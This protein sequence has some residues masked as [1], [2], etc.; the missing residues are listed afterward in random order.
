[1]KGN[2]LVW[3]ATALLV[4][5]GLAC[6]GG[7]T[8]TPEVPPT[9]EEQPTPEKKPAAEQQATPQ[10]KA[11]GPP[12][13]TPEPA[14]EGAT[15]EITNDSGVDVWYI[16]LSPSKA[17]RWGENWLGDHVIRNGE[18]HTIEGIPE[19]RYDVQ[20]ADQNEEVVEMWSEVDV[21]GVIPWSIE[22]LASLEVINE[23]STTIT[24][25]YIS[26]PEDTSW[27]DP[28]LS[29]QAIGP[30]ESLTIGDIPRGAYDVKV[31]DADGDAIEVIYSVGLA[32]ELSWE[33]IGKTS[34]PGNAVLRFEDEFE[35]NRNNWG[36]DVEG[37]DVFYK[38]PAN[39]QYC[40]LIKSENF[41]AWEWYEPFR[42]D[43]FVAEVFCEVAGAEG[44]TC[45]L[46]FGPDGDN[47]YWFEV[48]AGDQAF[49]F[50][51][52]ENG[53]WQEELV[54][55]TTSFRIDPDGSNA[56]SLERVGGVVSLI[57]NAV[58]V[59]QADGS[60]FPTGRVGIGGST[61]DVGYADVCLDNLRVWRLE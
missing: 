30:G 17:E 13:D 39:G 35:N 54:E 53:S 43:E 1:M 12:T 19:G 59:A 60:R 49:A 22:G 45:G 10:Q 44:A 3:L 51:L 15:L 52:L 8:P 57:I 48:S 58:L 47:L 20:V 38:R 2:R 33:V 55:W 21:E 16:Y 32:G 5:V 14:A 24:E 29:G 26:A 34:L 7:E 56:L 18:T 9:V 61:Y 23:S 42:P 36:L 11:S 28:W 41:T 27:G 50:K 6:G 25:L 37:E 4:I 46:G 31:A 40:I